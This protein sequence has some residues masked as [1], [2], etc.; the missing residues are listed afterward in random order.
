MCVVHVA[1]ATLPQSNELCVL[2]LEAEGGASATVIT[3]SV[4]QL[5]IVFG[6][7]KL[8]VVYSFHFK[9]GFNFFFNVIL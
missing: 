2:S 8:F 7:R 9:Y 1:A 3:T 5:N 4:L 6:H